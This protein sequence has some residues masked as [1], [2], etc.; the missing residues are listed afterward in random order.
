M[1]QVKADS[2][3]T[4]QHT[5]GVHYIKQYGIFGCTEYT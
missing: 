5:Y 1:M 2:D 3:S 4:L